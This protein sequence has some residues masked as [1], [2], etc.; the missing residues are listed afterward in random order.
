MAWYGLGLRAIDISDPY[1]PVEA[2]HYT[3]ENSE[4]VPGSETYDINFGPGG[5]LYVSDNSDGL[6]VLKY[7][8]KGMSGK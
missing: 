8:G 1:N 4:A 3:Y 5:L 7:T 2:G 6:R